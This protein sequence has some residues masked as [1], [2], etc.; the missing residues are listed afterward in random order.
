MQIDLWTLALQAI[1][2]LILVW[3][4]HR[5]LYRPLLAIIGRRR[6]QIDASLA[7]AGRREQAADD[8]RQQYEARLAALHEERGRLIKEAEALVER[9]R[10]EVLQRAQVE[11]QALREG[12]Q[13]QLGQEREAA[14]TSLVEE[15]T[16]LALDLASRLLRQVSGSGVADVFF[17]RV[18]Q[19]LDELAPERIEE[20]KSELGDGTALRLA[21]DSALDQDA[22]ASWQQRLADRL[23]PEL[24]IEFTTD[25]SLIAG[26]ELRFPHAVIGFSWRDSLNEARKELLEHGD[27][28]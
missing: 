1:N 8:A 21:T 9:Q 27:A 2:F 4:L 7:E 18:L 19:S 28:H 16:D 22:Q 6:E 24:R 12:A 5:F 25:D 15:G 20:L 17:E 11:A 14:A 10:Q 26:V 23:G 13:R 3:I